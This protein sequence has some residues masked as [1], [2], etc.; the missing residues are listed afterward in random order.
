MQGVSTHGEFFKIYFSLYNP[1]DKWHLISI[2]D[3]NLIIFFM[4]STFSKSYMQMFLYKSFKC[5]IL[6]LIQHTK[7]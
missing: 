3:L 6:Y 7:K 5:M 2:Y 4:I 1:I